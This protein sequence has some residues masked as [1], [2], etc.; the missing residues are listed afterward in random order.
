M[1]STILWTL[2]GIPVGY[3]WIIIINDIHYRLY[4]NN[5]SNNSKYSIITGITFFAFLRGYTGNDLITN[6]ENLM[7]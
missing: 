3:I 6:I 2:Y 1:I 7:F 5:I 4:N